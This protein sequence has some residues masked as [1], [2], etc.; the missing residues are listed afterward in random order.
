MN[1]QPHSWIYIQ[2]RKK[3]KLIWK[4]AYA[5]MFIAVIYS[6]Q[7]MKTTQVPINR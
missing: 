1:Q 7:D 6:I 5:P 2:K 3:K 4:N